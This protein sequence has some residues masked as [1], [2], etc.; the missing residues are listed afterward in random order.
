VAVLAVTAS[1]ACESMNREAVTLA[2]EVV[3]REDVEHQYVL[4]LSDADAEAL[5]LESPD[6]PD[7]RGD[8]AL[9][10]DHEVSSMRTW[11]YCLA[12]EAPILRQ[13]REVGVVPAGACMTGG[14]RRV[15]YEVRV[16]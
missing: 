15:A 9:R 10:T 2:I 5:G 7:D 8:F 1:A 4:H 13:G 14:A 16:T 11:E 3:P 12:D 6:I